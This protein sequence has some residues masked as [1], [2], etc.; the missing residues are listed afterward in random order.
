[1][2]K[3]TADQ[4]LMLDGMGWKFVP[5]GPNEFEWLKFNNFNVCIAR[6][7]SWVWDEDIKVLGR[8]KATSFEDDE[9][10]KAAVEAMPP[11]PELASP[12]VPEVWEP[13]MNLRIRCIINR[14]RII[15]QKFVRT[16]G[17]PE[18]GGGSSEWRAL[19]II[20]DTTV[21]SQ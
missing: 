1:M 15:E 17:G 6:G 20:I 8:A 12:V 2:A 13:T 10:L 14:E 11:E 16:A 4:I 21:R 19:P 18:C 5:T 9:D 3:F 7:G